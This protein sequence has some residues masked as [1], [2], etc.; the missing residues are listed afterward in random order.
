ML[1]RFLQS[2]KPILPR[3]VFTFSTPPQHNPREDEPVKKTKHNPYA[4]KDLRGY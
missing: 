1:I 2:F 3:N 4:N